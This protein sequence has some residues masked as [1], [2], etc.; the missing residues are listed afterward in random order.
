[1]LDRIEA[2]LPLVNVTPPT[3]PGQAGALLALPDGSLIPLT[4]DPDLP[5]IFFALGES[6]TIGVV[7]S[8]A[9]EKLISGTVMDR[10]K[11]AMASLRLPS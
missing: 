1:M 5:D 3:G 9:G 2:E 10:L 6:I 11:T 8:V 7:A 4:L